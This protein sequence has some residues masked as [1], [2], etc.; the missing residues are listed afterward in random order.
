MST[1]PKALHQGEHWRFW[2]IRK[3]GAGVEIDMTGHTFEGQIRTAAA[4][5][6]VVASFACT[7]EASPV[8]SA[9]N[10]A[11]LCDLDE[12]VTITIPARQGYVYDIFDIA[13]G[14]DRLFLRGGTINV[15]ARVTR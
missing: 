3:D 14:G 6:T 10:R 11:C 15:E 7:L 8:T 12:S 5:S 13:P 1:V 9:A 2:I 4:S